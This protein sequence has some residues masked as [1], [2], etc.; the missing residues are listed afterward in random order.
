MRIAR[1]QSLP[2]TKNGESAFAAKHFT[3]WSVT[4]ANSKHLIPYQIDKKIANNIRAKMALKT[5]FEKLESN[6]SL[7]F[8][9]QTDQERYLYFTH[10]NGCHSYIGQQK[11]SGPQDITLG[12]GC[13]YYFTIIHE[14]D[15]LNHALTFK[16]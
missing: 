4:F 13:Y 11:K 1:D 5:A 14:V 2:T 3:P 8:I 7:K 10:G 12:D 6:S 9:E 16:F 15:V